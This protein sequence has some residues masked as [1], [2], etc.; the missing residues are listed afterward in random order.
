MKTESVECI[1]NSKIVQLH[2]SSICPLSRMVR[3]ALLEQKYQLH[4]VEENYVHDNHEI[5]AINPLGT[6][7]FMVFQDN[8]VIKNLW[9]IIDYIINK[10]DIFGHTVMPSFLK[11]FERAEILFNV[12]WFCTKF[13]ND[14]TL[15]IIQ[16]KIVNFTTKRIPPNSTSIRNALR[17]MHIHMEYLKLSL[18]ESNYI[19]SSTPTI[20]DYS[21][22]AQISILDYTGDIMWNTINKRIKGWYSLIKS[23]P[24][25]RTVLKDR[26]LSLSPPPHYEDPDF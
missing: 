2:Y 5:L 10:N 8:T 14:V 21:A 3:I 23:R 16:Q 20:A 24:S 15:P 17:N 9:G 22:A 4:L 19:E 11:N 12:E 26:I 7:P 1:D 18:A 6:L 13:F 25:F